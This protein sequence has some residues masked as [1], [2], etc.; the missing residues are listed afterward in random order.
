MSDWYD[1]E[2]DDKPRTPKFAKT[3]D[4]E[5]EAFR[6][7]YEQYRALT[8]NA[9]MLGAAA[10]GKKLQWRF[11]NSTDQLPWG[12]LKI[13]VTPSIMYRTNVEFRIKPEVIRFRC[14]L[15][16]NGPLGCHYVRT[17]LCKEGEE[18][19]EAS[20][21]AMQPGFTRWIDDEWRTVEV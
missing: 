1:E 11:K 19:E 13:L 5:I 7:L 20:A 15:R 3:A 17:A 21:T 18:L 9:V 2:E 4:R 14:W 8:V 10:D 12:D 16:H 6:K